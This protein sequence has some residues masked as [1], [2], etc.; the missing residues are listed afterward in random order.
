M[1]TIHNYF[2][3]I[4]ECSD[5]SYYVGVTNDLEIRLAQHNSGENVFSYTFSRRP[6]L[7]KY[8]QRFDQIEDAIDFEKQV[9]GWSRRKKEALFNEDWDEIVRLS[10]YKK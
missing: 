3:Y 1:P 8:F 10:N 4:L 9:K 2:V 6:V 7:L 5:K